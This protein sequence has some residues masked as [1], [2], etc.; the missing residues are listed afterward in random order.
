[1]RELWDVYGEDYARIEGRVA[2]RGKHDLAPHEYHL[3]VYAWIVSDD[4]RVIISR[5]QKGRSFGGSW[6]C[7]GGCAKQGEDSQTAILREVREEL[8]LTLLAE[9]GRLYKRYKRRFPMGAKAICD[10]FIFR[11]NVSLEELTLQ[12]SEVSEVRQIS[13]DELLDMQNR[14]VF[15]KRYP[16]IEEMLEEIRKEL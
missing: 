8:G 10:V 2:V 1:M 4:G 13:L 9:E 3:I 16:Y 11:R 15:R 14:G 5:R 12:K 6:E 7:T